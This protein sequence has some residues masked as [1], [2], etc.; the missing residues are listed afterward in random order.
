[1]IEHLEFSAGVIVNCQGIVVVPLLYPL[2]AQLCQYLETG[3][4]I[5]CYGMV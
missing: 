5:I 2:L 3:R 1:M 4:G